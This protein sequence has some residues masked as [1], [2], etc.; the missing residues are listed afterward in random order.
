MEHIEERRVIAVT[1]SATYRAGDDVPRALSTISWRAVLAGVV[2]ALAVQI[3]LT[4]LGLA[5]G[6]TTLDAS[7]SRDVLRATGIGVGVW[8]LVSSLI[9]VFCGGLVAGISARELT[10]TMGSIEGLLV[11]A[12]SLLLMIWFVS[13]GVQSVIAQASGMLTVDPTTLSGADVGGLQ[14]DMPIDQQT[15]D[16]IAGASTVA[17]WVAF[18]TLLLSAICGTIGGIVGA[19]FNR[20]QVF[21]SVVRSRQVP[22]VQP[23]ERPVDLRPSEV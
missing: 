17:S 3:L 1:P 6:A 8:Y 22:V 20:R 18:G 13:S 2:V 7:T 9:S 15:A 10:R 4:T 19:R 21:R 23:V 14:R 5:I 11:W 16:Q 12:V